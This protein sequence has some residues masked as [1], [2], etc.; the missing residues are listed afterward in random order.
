MEPSVL[1]VEARASFA[2]FWTAF[3]PRLL[4]FSASC[5]CAAYQLI[6]LFVLHISSWTQLYFFSCAP[7]QFY[8]RCS[9]GV[10]CCDVSCSG[11]V[12]FMGLHARLFLLSASDLVVG[13][14]APA[15]F[16]CCSSRTESDGTF[17]AFMS[18]VFWIQ[19]QFHLEVPGAFWC[20]HRSWKANLWKHVCFNRA[21]LEAWVPSDLTGRFGPSVGGKLSNL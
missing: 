10:M 3:V 8:P 7:L 5:S 15:S 2:R 16:L 9:S 14:A 11:C 17:G 18:S 12:C 21:A 19:L 4:F 6:A 13:T 1:A 20:W